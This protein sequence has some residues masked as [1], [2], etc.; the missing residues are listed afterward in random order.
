MMTDESDDAIA[1]ATIAVALYGSIR[2]AARETNT[3]YTT[4]HRQYRR[5]AERGLLGTNPVLPGFALAK[6]TSVRDKTGSVVREFVTQKKAHGG[7]FKAPD[8]HGVK[9]VSALVDAEGRVVQQWVKTNRDDEARLAA[10]HTMVDELKTKLPRVAA[11][12][13]PEHVNE[14]LLNQFTVTDSH[15]GMLAWAE[16]TKDASYD[17]AI[18][19]KLLT[20]WFS[21]AIALAPRA[22]VAVLAQLGDLMHHDA[23][24]SVTPAHRNVLDA[25][26]RLQKVIRVV[27]RVVRRI[28]GMLLETHERVHV[29]MATGNHDPAS[30]AWLRELLHA[31]YEH[32][33]RITIDNSPGHY[34]AYEFGKTALFYHHGDKRKV[35]DVDRTFAGMFRDIYGRCPHSYGHIGHL[36][37]DEAVDGALMKVERHRTLA[38]RDAFAAAGGWLSNRDAKV[39]TYHREFGEVR[40]DTLSPRMVAAFKEAA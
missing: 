12:P 36:H 27:I 21:A 13:G 6:T 15:F 7:E 8:G 9:G 22:K 37:N 14:A 33:P 39:I 18:A 20:D 5:A 10:F 28:I 11:A 4:M 19:E 29:V 25:D 40:R 34:Y 23:L 24:E 32:E 26:S 16:E 1:R 17:L 35:G 30:S 3:P 2:A 38:P 31:M